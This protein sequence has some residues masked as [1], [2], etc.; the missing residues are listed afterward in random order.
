MSEN[1]TALDNRVTVKV[2]IT[3]ELGKDNSQS[4]QLCSPSMRSQK[5]GLNLLR[6]RK[7]SHM[8]AS[9]SDMSKLDSRTGSFDGSPPTPTSQPTSNTDTFFEISK[10]VTS[11]LNLRAVIDKVLSLAVSVV[12]AERCSLFLIDESTNQLYSTAWDVKKDEKLLDKVLDSEIKR[13][14]K[15]QNLFGSV[16]GIRDLADNSVGISKDSIQVG[17]P[18]EENTHEVESDSEGSMDAIFESSDNDSSSAALL[19]SKNAQFKFP[20]GTG[21]AGYVAQTGKGLNVPNAYK[22]PRFNKEFD[23]KVNYCS[24][25]LYR[26]LLFFY[27]SIRVDLK[28]KTSFAFPSTAA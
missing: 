15:K 17:V 21:I 5:T 6:D 23:L 22:E 13:A 16:E 10:A 27:I 11:S 14:L 18:N 12:K 26:I 20:I 28:P 25:N 8:A 1:N 19:S 24:I 7:L 3:D 4:T 9:L 2:E